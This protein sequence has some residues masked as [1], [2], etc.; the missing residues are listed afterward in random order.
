MKED[1]LHFVWKHKLFLQ[2]HLFTA[3]GEEVEVINPGSLNDH[4]GP[5]F[6]DA[7][8]RIGSTLWAGNVELHFR[9]SDW[10]KH[11]HHKDASYRN[12]ILHVVLEDDVSVKNDIGAI[13]PS[14][15][16][17]WPH[18]IE[19]NY[20]ALIKNRD[21]VNCASYLYRVDPFKIRFFLN[22][23]LI[24]R[25]EDKIEVIDRTLKTAKEDWN[26]VFYWFM[27]RSFGFGEN[28]DPF[29]RVA[30][31]LPQSVLA[32][33][34]DS[35]FQIEALLFGQ[36]GLLNTELFGDDYYLDLKKEY[37]FLAAKYGL[38]PIEG[39][40]WKFM[41]MH[42]VN[43]PT[44]RLSQ[45]AAL[46]HRSRGLFSCVLDKKNL[47][48]LQDLFVINASEYWD[49]H[50]T[51][52]KESVK[53]KKIFGD[54]AFR[55]ILINVVVPFLFLYGNR[56]NKSYLKDRALEMLE[57]LPPENNRVIRRWEVAGIAA[58]NAL[59]S[60]A[61]LHLQQNYCLPVRC[62]ECSIGH[63][64]ILHSPR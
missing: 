22:S 36:S 8:I 30:R 34:L 44:V 4:D 56:N 49:T 54:Q 9:A 45:F 16:I 28:N 51:F 55:L 10:N 3:E 57:Q 61:L 2:D 17:T 31:S 59:E 50:Y 24:E 53:K 27:A 7:R 11:N 40:L 5:D 48:D 6:F 12:T 35:L 32:R 62:L 39:H 47:G 63:R 18:W 19:A 37:Q 21:W 26:E 13:I 23:I 46:I 43:F 41:R 33:H 25:L 1:F 58:A 20:T 29:E 52:N 14:M 38:T 64:I 42:P 60:Q 15:K